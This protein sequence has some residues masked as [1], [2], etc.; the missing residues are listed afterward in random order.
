MIGASIGEVVRRAT[1]GSLQELYEEPN[2][3]PHGLDHYLGLSEAREAR[4]VEMQPWLFT[5]SQHAGG[6]RAASD[7][8]YLGSLRQLTAFPDR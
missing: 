5:A 3:A 6:D 8:L 4:Y 1:G 2:R 7:R